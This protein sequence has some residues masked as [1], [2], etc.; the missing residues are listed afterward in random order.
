MA[1]SDSVAHLATIASFALHIGGGAIG[2]IAGTIAIFAPKGERIHRAA[3]NVFF[4][5]MVV[6][7]LFSIYLAIVMPD[8]KVNIFIGS[9]TLYLVSTGW[10]TVQRGEGAIGLFEK[11]ATLVG[12][13]LWAPFAVLSFQLAAGMEPLFRSAVPFKGPVL[14]AIYSFTTILTIA[15][16]SDVKLMLTGGIAGA[17][18]IARHLWRMC[19]GLGLAY[20][21]GFTNGF[22]RLL[23]GPYHVP[24][25]FFFPQFAPVLLMVFWMIRVRLTGWYR[26]QER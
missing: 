8:Q 20:G 18:R 25:A 14:I 21:S 6:M 23:P 22:A 13:L 4:G 10:V 26:Q 11:A 5:A 3:G 19:L 24:P 15:A 9:F 1:A 16:A 7:A 2:L 17:P 12:L